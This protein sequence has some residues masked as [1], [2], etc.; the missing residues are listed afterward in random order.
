V[1]PRLS[2]QTNH[3]LTRVDVLVIGMFIIPLILFLASPMMIFP[4]A[5]RR[6]QRINCVSNLKQINL[7]L[8]IWEGDNNNTYPMSVSITNG[9]AMELIATGN[10]AACFQAMSNRLGAAKFLI[11]PADTDHT[12]ATSFTTGFD[13]SHI[14]YFINPDASESYPQEIM[15]GDDNLAINGMPVKSGLLLLPSNA[16]V[17]WTAARHHFV[18]NIAFADGSVAEA[19]AAS[20]QSGLI[21]STNGTPIATPRLAIP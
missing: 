4:A 16:S 18:G 7:A 2:T 21:L 5:K 3:A 17:S 6:A 12:P 11:C 1:N 8:R 20:L 14:S 9:G 10:V 19:S 15:L 13:N